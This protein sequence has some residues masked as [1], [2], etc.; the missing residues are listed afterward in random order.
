MR[1]LLSGGGTAGHINPAIAIAQ[2][3]KSHDKDAEIA[4]VGRPYGME[5]ELIRKEGFF[6][7]TVDTAGLSRS[8]HPK[9]LRALYLAMVSPWRAQK[10]LDAFMPDVVIGTGSFVCWPILR[11]AVRAKIPCILHES[12]A[13]PGLAVRKLEKLGCKILL[14]FESAKEGLIHKDDAVTVGNPLR[15]GFQTADRNIERKSLGLSESDRMILAFGGSRGAEHLNEALLELANNYVA[16]N[17]SVHLFFA[18]GATHYHLCHS[19]L[20]EHHINKNSRI[21]LLPYIDN[22]P[23]L[24]A[25]ADIVICR[26]GAMTLSEVAMCGKC[27]IFV[28]SPY[29]ANNHQFRNAELPS[30]VGAS[31][32]LEEK[33]LSAKSLERQL[34]MLL[35]NDDLRLS[36]GK[37]IKT[38]A[39]PDANTRIWYEIKKALNANQHPEK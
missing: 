7:F 26:A 31:C 32:L 17:S 12:N 37:Q 30:S 24:M 36:M 28:P 38:F 4:F 13:I 33:N 20:T 39:M 11:A 25:A 5:K 22:M 19:W 1:Y 14:N 9:N 35:A 27:A 3:I 2:I 29:V 16:K 21:H 6:Y 34:R 23:A 15:H 8:F 18:T 10:V